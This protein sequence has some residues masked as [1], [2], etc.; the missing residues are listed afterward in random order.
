M[1]IDGRMD[2]DNDEIPPRK[3][4]DKKQYVRVDPQTGKPQ[5]IRIEPIITSEG[6]FLPDRV[7]FF[8]DDEMRI[9]ERDDAEA[10]LDLLD[11]SSLEIATQYKNYWTH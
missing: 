5:L 1:A 9:M 2:D 8:V 3:W 10:L 6:E 7:M 11:C 4:L